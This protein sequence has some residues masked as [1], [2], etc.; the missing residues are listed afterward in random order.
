MGKVELAWGREGCLPSGEAEGALYMWSIMQA[1]LKG[2]SFYSV[3]TECA[4]SQ[5]SSRSRSTHYLPFTPLFW[6]SEPE[7]RESTDSVWFSQWEVLARVQRAEEEVMG[8]FSPLVPEKPHFWWKWHP[9]PQ[10]MFNSPSDSWGSHLVPILSLPPFVQDLK[11]IQT[12]QLC[13]FWGLLKMDMP[14][15]VKKLIHPWMNG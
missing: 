13:H 11:E 6:A 15:I 4:V 3:H 14:C 5:G 1:P 8:Y 12:D 7:S 9:R 2:R 10:P